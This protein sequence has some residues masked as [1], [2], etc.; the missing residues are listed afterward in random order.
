MRYFV[1]DICV[2]AEAPPELGFVE[3]FG[4]VPW[5]LDARSWPKCRE[6]GKSQSLLAQLL[7]HPARLDLGR[8]GRVLFVFQCSH[9]PGMCETWNRDS[10]ANACFVVEPEM[11]GPEPSAIPS[12]LP[13]LNNEVHVL[14]W[15]ERDDGVPPPLEGAFYSDATY[16]ELDESVIERPAEQTRLGSVPTWIQ[17]PDEGPG[18]GWQFAG[19]L[20]WDHRFMSPP[21]GKYEWID[22]APADDVT[23]IGQGPNFGDCGIAYLFVRK[24]EDPP[25]G[26]M[27]WQCS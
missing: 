9:D 1:P 22:D 14:R 13:P 23:H 21:K 18:E 25:V 6:C 4:G 8:S 19:Q 5:G 24:D 27:F 12:D 10:G 20:T 11:L 16:G 17:S 2:A 26:T 3:K 15:L 7:H